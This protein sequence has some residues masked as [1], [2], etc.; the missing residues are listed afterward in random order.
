M[1]VAGVGALGLSVCKFGLG[2]LGGFGG[3]EALG[4]RV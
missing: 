2:A 3:L 1:V 4:L